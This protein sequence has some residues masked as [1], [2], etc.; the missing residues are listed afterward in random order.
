ME[1][2]A[3]NTEQ[4]QKFA[5][6]IA[7]KLK[8]GNTVALYGD[9]GAGKTTFVSMVTKALGFSDR[10]QSPTFVVS[11]IYSGGGSSSDIKYV[12]HLD[13]YRMHDS[14]DVKELGMEDYLN[15]SDSVTFI[16][17]P[18]V[19]EKYLPE[20]TIRIFFEILSENERK[21]HVQNLH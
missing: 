16:E 3:A 18:E 17:W 20:K 21:I 5:Q 1:I 12:H 4:T 10:V 2:V 19:A 9:L 6:E 15:Q 14:G 8:P 13:L 11:R 7:L